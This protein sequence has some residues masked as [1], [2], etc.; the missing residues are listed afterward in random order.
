MTLSASIA[1]APATVSGSSLPLPIPP[2]YSTIPDCVTATW[3]LETEGLVA[4]LGADPRLAYPVEE[5]R[6]RTISRLFDL[7]V[8]EFRYPDGTK[9][10]A[11]D[12]RVAKIVLEVCPVTV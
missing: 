11:F 3:P 2:G 8:V 6:A 1:S 7:P 10:V 12:K 4:D 9:G 5:D